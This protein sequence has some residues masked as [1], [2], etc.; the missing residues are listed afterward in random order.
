M[1]FRL[2]CGVVWCNLASFHIILYIKSKTLKLFFKE[3]ELHVLTQTV[4][5]V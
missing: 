1:L 3:K 2:E 5:Q 4:E